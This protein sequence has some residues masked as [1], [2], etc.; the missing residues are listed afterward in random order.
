MLN[1]FILI[2]AKRQKCSWNKQPSK[3]I[4]KNSPTTANIWATP[5]TPAQIE[6]ERC[7][8]LITQSMM[9]SASNNRLLLGEGKLFNLT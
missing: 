2:K 1:I 6:N 7:P 4:P 9:Y 8:S 3:C 5:Q